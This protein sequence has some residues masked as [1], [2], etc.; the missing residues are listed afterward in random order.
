MSDS[1]INIQEELLKALSGDIEEH[2]EKAIDILK[3][4]EAQKQIE[5]FHS[6]VNHALKEVENIRRKPYYSQ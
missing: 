2:Y 6:L 5:D 3:D 4:E 1:T